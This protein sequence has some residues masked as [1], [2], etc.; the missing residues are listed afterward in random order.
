MVNP[1]HIRDGR[2]EPS[3]DS[4]VPFKVAE[5]LRIHALRVGDIV[6]GRKGD[7]GR[8]ALVGER[9][10]GWIAGSDTI[11][12]RTS[13]SRLSPRF[14]VALLHLD[15]VRQQLEARSTGATLANVNEA[16]LLALRVPAP[17]ADEQERRASAVEALTSQTRQ[18]VEKLNKQ[19]ALLHEHK[20]ALISST[21]A[22]DFEAF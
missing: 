16:I 17:P 9:E 13:S 12:L 1:T 15:L 8:S 22:G 18:L 4:R 6:L 5:R 11:V 3:E 14:L 2:I 21:T 10:Q 7:V 20:S 19:I